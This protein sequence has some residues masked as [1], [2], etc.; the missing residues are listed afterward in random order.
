MHRMNMRGFIA[1]VAIASM[2]ACAALDKA[3]KVSEKLEEA[4]LKESLA[5]GFE[6]TSCAESARSRHS[7][8]RTFCNQSP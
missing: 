4:R 1:V 3:G 8:H 5:K 6:P 7:R 2:S